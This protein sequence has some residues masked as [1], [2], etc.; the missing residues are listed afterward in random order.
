MALSFP[1]DPEPG[2]TYVAPNG[3]TYTWDGTKWSVASTGT[4]SVG[5]TPLIVRD[6][7]TTINTATTTLNFVGALITA[8]TTGTAVTITVSAAPLTTATTATL[9]GVKIGSGISINDGIIS[10]REGLQYWTESKADLDTNNAVISLAAL[11]S[12]TNATAV[13]LAQGVGAVAADS[14]GHQRGD[15]AV[16]WQKQRGQDT[17]VASGHYSVIGGG[18]FNTAN[19]LHSVIVGGNNNI[20]DAEYGVILGGVNGNTR[21]IQVAVI[22]PG[23]A[24]G[25]TNN[26]SGI[27]Q[28]GLYILGGVTV[29]STP[30]TLTTD[31]NPTVAANNQISLTSYQSTYFKGTVVG[32]QIN[33]TNPEIAVWNVEGVV[34]KN[35][36]STSTN[37]YFSG[38]LSPQAELISSI[39]SSTAWAVVLDVDN[40]LGCML[41]NVQGQVGK[42]VRWAAKVETIEI[43]DL[44]M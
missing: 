37:Y 15:Y 7:G 6:E 43:T 35:A 16:D 24:T 36:T 38:A 19:A 42:D 2:D 11:S 4:G 30:Q 10:V 28:T 1:I 26:S 34:R 39:N 3:Y 41:I 23:Y 44:G 20:N 31:G 33:V 21:G 40:T 32:K 25:G 17:Q 22:T 12:G 5:G 13:L 27:I 18:S 29:S 9:G 14:A 8:T